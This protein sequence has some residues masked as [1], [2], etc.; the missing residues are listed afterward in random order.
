MVRGRG[1]GAAAAGQQQTSS[2]SSR[3]FQPPP[4]YSKFA[5][6][7]SSTAA[8][9]GSGSVGHAPASTSNQLHRG[10]PPST[11][12]QRDIQVPELLHLIFT[13]LPKPSLAAC[14]R[15]NRSWFPIVIEHL[16][17]SVNVRTFLKLS[18]RY[19]QVADLM[20]WGPV[21]DDLS[22]TVAE[23]SRLGVYA[24]CISVFE[25]SYHEATGNDVQRPPDLY[26]ELII[27][28]W[29]D[30][31]NQNPHL[32]PIPHG[33]FTHPITDITLPVLF[34]RLRGLRGS[35]SHS[36]REGCQNAE[37]LVPFR[38]MH[39]IL[40]PLTSIYR[41]EP[42][43]LSLIATKSTEIVMDTSDLRQSIFFEFKKNPILQ[44][45]EFTRRSRRVVRDD[46]DKI[47]LESQ[48]GW[49]KQNFPYSLKP[50]LR[51]LTLRA[52]DVH[53][54]FAQLMDSRMFGPIT[55]IRVLCLRN[56]SKTARQYESTESRSSRS[57]YLPRLVDTEDELAEETG[58]DAAPWQGKTLTAAGMGDDSDPDVAVT[59]TLLETASF[60]DDISYFDDPHF[61]APTLPLAVGGRSRPVPL[62][63]A[64]LAEMRASSR[65]V[66]LAS[67]RNSSTTRSSQSPPP[68][69][70][71]F[72]TDDDSHNGEHDNDMDGSSAVS[73]AS[74]ARR[75]GRSSGASSSPRAGLYNAES[76][77]DEDASGAGGG[78]L[79]NPLGFNF[80]NDTYTTEDSATDD[81]FASVSSDGLEGGASPIEPPNRTFL[82]LIAQSC[83][84]LELLVLEEAWDFD[85]LTAGG[86]LPGSDPVG[87]E[88]PEMV[89]GT[90]SRVRLRVNFRSIDEVE[91][92]TEVL[93]KGIRRAM[94]Q[95]S[96]G[97][98][99]P[100][101]PR[102]F[103]LRPR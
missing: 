68:P 87:S 83:P 47:L 80:F 103:F 18:G 88:E 58:S 56:F 43:T 89:P 29:C 20:A 32:L 48:A 51:H 100:K 67:S 69:P 84:D 42:L 38:P 61:G 13:Y 64:A 73:D 4:N 26:I 12:A 25:F 50:P 44:K 57:E 82:Q 99:R 15:V 33:G 63:E 28:L 49:T 76:S 34:P 41:T 23:V 35:T 30:I 1:R 17:R 6:T 98:R 31:L 24:P 70:I 55:Q 27:D 97:A 7:R 9:A 78:S 65:D 21:Q 2:F 72:E 10:R 101:L 40:R 59:S 74:R 46:W 52:F 60:D 8:T 95:K 92:R 22:L 54:V 36:F 16:W 5:G 86:A 53:F 14:A 45:L 96:I 90:L 66:D 75:H 91:E 19:R 81:S 37:F 79:W 11:T 3:R 71:G 102:G 94:K 39:G 85:R 93:E 62:T 77:T